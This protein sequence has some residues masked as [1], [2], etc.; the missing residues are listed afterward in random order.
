[1]KGKIT[2][3]LFAIVFFIVGFI[4]REILPLPYHPIVFTPN[5]SPTPSHTEF[6]VAEVLDGDTIRIDTGELVRYHGIDAPEKNEMYGQSATKHNKEYVL[7][8]T[9]RLEYDYQNQDQYGRIL[10]YVWMD[11][12]FINEKMIEEGYATF[13]TIPKTRKLKYADRLQNAQQWAKDHHNGMWIEE[14]RE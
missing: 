7:G 9:V 4:S 1:M 12:T 6:T 2:L 3:I 11:E 14:W 5:I 10:A 8:K 13:Y